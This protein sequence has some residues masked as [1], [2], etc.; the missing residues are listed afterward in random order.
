MI[1]KW[2]FVVG[3]VLYFFASTTAFAHTAITKRFPEAD[4]LLETAPKTVD[5]YFLDPVEVHSNSII[6][7]SEQ[8]TEVQVGIAQLDPKDVHHVS[9]NLQ[10]NL[11]PGKYEINLD[12]VALDGHPVR[13]NYSFEIKKSLEEELFQKLKLERT[14]PEDGSILPSSPQKIELWYT[15][16]AEIFAF[17]LLDDKQQLLSSIIPTR[18]PNDSKHYTLNLDSEL[19]EGTYAIQAFVQ[20]GDKQ[21]F[22]TKYFAVKSF[23]PITSSAAV[24]SESVF[25]Q[26]GFLQLAHWLTFISILTLT[27]LNLF[28]L[29]IDNG[30]GNQV[31][32]KRFSQYLFGV[33]LLAVALGLIL[34]KFRYS[35]IVLKDYIIFNFVWIPVLQLAFLGL[36]WFFKGR[37]RSLFLILTILC[38]SF[39]GH[40]IAPSYGGGWGVILTFLHLLGVTYWIGGLVAFLL[41][42]PGESSARWLKETGRRFSRGA[43]VSLILIG[44]TGFWMFLNYVP[45][46]SFESLI[47]SNW[48]QLLLAKIVL[49]LGIGLIG[50]WQRKFIIQMAEATIRVFLRFVKVEIGAAALIL[51]ATA[52]LIDLSP[53]EAE[54][55]I[56]PKKQIQQGIEARMEIAPLKAGANVVSVQFN[57]AAE[58]QKVDVKYFSST[59]W[60][61]ENKAFSFGDGLFKVTGNL[62]H[63][64]GTMNVIVEAVKTNGET[65]EFPFKVQVP[66]VMP[67]DNS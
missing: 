51:L 36:G 4:S 34:N 14:L 9:V 62:F 10:P 58:F 17:G 28:Q 5:V 53:K 55:G 37:I 1:K 35:E 8:K 49:Y 48:G 57:K 59:D 50:Y 44:I 45:S 52:I 43:I 16:P 18:D 27:G 19:K 40:A 20:I 39:T 23:T 31:R 3:A 65:V 11:A 30:H 21:K 24:S 64:A 25:E 32:L 12:V 67:T 29:F 26:L 33:S 41:M 13:E 54:Q 42:V 60:V 47:T 7:R 22:E 15:V 2:I 6:V 56:F 38:F 46:F 61:N 66:G 63:G